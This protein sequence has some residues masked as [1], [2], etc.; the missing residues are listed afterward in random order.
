LDIWELSAVDLAAALRRRE[1][2]AGL[3]LEAVLQRANQIE[4]SVNPF[5]LRLD[6][7][8]RRAAAAADA[9][10]ARGEGGP[11]CGVPVT[12]KDSHWMAGV[13]CTSASRARIGVVP[14]ET[15]AAIERLEAAGAVIFARTTTPEFCYFGVT[16]SA[17]FGRTSNPWNLERTAGGSSGGGGAAVAAG[18][19][20][21]S[22]GGDGGG[23]IRIPAAF[24]GIVGFKPTFGLVPHEPS[25][26]GWKTLIAVGPMAR[27]VADTR[28]M[29]RAIVGPDPRDRHSTPPGPLDIPAPKPRALHVIASEDLGFAPLDD[30]VRR[31]FRAAVA[32]LADAGVSIISDSPRLGSSVH[33]WSTIA[34]AEAR[35][36]EAEEYE[37]NRDL[38]SPAA[39]EFIAAGEQVTATQYIQAQ[40][41]R[42]RIHRAYV[43]LFARTGAAVLLTPTVGCEAFPH[44]RH[45]PDKI[46]GIPIAYPNLDWA[47]FLY[48]ANLAGLPTCAI[49]IG[50]GDDGLPV[51]MQVLGPRRDDGRVLAAA[52]TIE[53]LIGFTARP[54]VDPPPPSA[55]RHVATSP[56]AKSRRPR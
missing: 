8:A 34:T 27:S 5:S 19:G 39:V 26:P 25:S 12:T 23:S 24:C 35:Y 21:L 41:A 11:L 53:A 37:R 56:T 4:R 1:L 13:E 45:H 44:G 38:L 43:D 32:R 36:S 40:F 30:D 14:A 3:A 49:P 31:T 18:V 2:S 28:F 15:V 55:T 52:E 48:D 42:E 50:L 7:R 54:P 9:A 22:L 33:V 20:P 47:P 51:S 16:E 46:G 6:D 29:L 10:L 17:L